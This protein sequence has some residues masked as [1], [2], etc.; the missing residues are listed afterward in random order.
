MKYLSVLAIAVAAG[1]TTLTAHSGPPYPILSNMAAGGYVISLWADPDA[2]DDGSAAGR[3]WVMLDPAD[4][5]ASLPADTHAVIKVW[6]AE[7]PQSIRTVNADKVAQDVSRQY[8]ALVM[9]HEGRY[10]VSVSVAGPLG[11]AEISAAVDATYDL[12]PS[13][14][15]LGVSLMPFGL[16]GFLWWTML[17][18]RA[19][20][21]KTQR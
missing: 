15:V 11:P 13:P 12:R 14:L 1:A 2:T 10:G 6:P 18:R 21:R 5:G 7:D 4:K 17:R 16:V 20:W 3:F 9:D 19:Q 8:A